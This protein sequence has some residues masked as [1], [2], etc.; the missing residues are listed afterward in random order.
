MGQ[1][2]TDNF[3][4]QRKLVLRFTH[5]NRS[6]EFFSK[7]ISL[8]SCNHNATQKF[9]E[10]KSML[11]AEE[12][13]LCKR[14]TI[15]KNNHREVKKVSAVLK[16][17]STPRRDGSV[18]LLLC[19]LQSFLWKSTNLLSLSLHLVT[20]FLPLSLPCPGLRKTTR[21]TQI[22]TRACS[23]LCREGMH[24]QQL[25]SPLFKRPVKPIQTFPLH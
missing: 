1:S 7:V 9:L 23:P 20:N 13:F 5:V 10:S 24:D 17:I 21:V 4:E 18:E 6:P 19:S 3:Q 12:P 11:R 2:Q 15:D 16:V 14:K 22:S 25:L 8:K